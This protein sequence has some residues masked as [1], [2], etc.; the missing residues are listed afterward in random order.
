VNGTHDIFSD[1]FE[2]S[3]WAPSAHV[4]TGADLTISPHVGLTGEL[5]YAYAKGRLSGDY[6]GFRDGIDLSGATATLGLF[7][8]F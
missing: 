2:S 3:G 7:F 5:R 1:Q 6:D 4:M 8:R